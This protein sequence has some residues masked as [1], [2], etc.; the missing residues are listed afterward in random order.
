MAPGVGTPTQPR[1]AAILYGLSGPPQDISPVRA[2]LGDMERHLFRLTGELEEILAEAHGGERE[3]LREL[4]RSLSVTALRARQARA[5]LK[6]AVLRD[7][8]PPR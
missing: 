7:E 4:W 2:L 8:D 1:R 3:L 5:L 6:Y